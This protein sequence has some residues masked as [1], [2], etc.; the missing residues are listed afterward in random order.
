MTVRKCAQFAICLTLIGLPP[1]MEAGGA[2]PEEELKAA[3]VMSFLQYTEWSSLPPGN[4]PLTLGVWG[5]T[6][7]AQVLQRSLE[8][9]PVNGRSVRVV[10][11][12]P[13]DKPTWQI[14]YVVADR[15]AEIKAG[16]LAVSAPGVLTIGESEGFLESGGTVNL[17]AIDGRMSFEF[18]MEALQQSGVN[19]SSRLLRFGQMRRVKGSA[20]GL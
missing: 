4:A 10:Q 2:D 9:K 19:I 14:A 1:R 20:P 7:F 16:L 6:T 17:L 5:G 15:R 11:I 8:S 18:S 12:R 13:G 3:I